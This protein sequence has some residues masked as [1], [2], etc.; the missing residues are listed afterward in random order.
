MVLALE[1]PDS[2][3][4]TLVVS[5]T[6]GVVVL[7]ILLQGST[8]ALLLRRTGLAKPTGDGRRPREHPIGIAQPP[9]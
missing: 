9:A 4:R 8:M 2:A 5:T 6:Y 1:L 3:T 7:S